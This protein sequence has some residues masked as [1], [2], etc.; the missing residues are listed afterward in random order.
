MICNLSESV[1][2]VLRLGA[3]VMLLLALASTG[4]AQV[5]AG[6]IR[7]MLSD[8]TGA[9]IP[10]AEVR[11]TNLATGVL[12]STQTTGAGVF[13]LGNLPVGDYRVEAESPGF[14]SFAQE[15][16]HVATASTTNL[17]IGLEV[18]EVTETVTV[19]GT[20]TPLL[21]T[22]TAELSTVMERKVVMDLPLALGMTAGG[23]SG[24]RQIEGFIYLTPGVTG[25]AWGK[26]FNGAPQ[27]MSQSVV[28]GI[29]HALQE[30]PGLLIRSGPPYEAVQ[31][32]KVSTAMYPAEQG[33]AFGI[34]NYTFKSG[35]NEFHGNA[36]WF[37]RNNK[38]DASGFYNAAA[39]I[40][41]QNELGATIGGPII[42]SKTFFHVAYQ[43]FS[44]RGGTSSIGLVNIPPVAFRQGDFGALKA[45]GE[46]IPI[47]DPAST[48]EDG[49]GGF[50]RDPYPNNRIPSAQISSIANQVMGFLPQP[51]NPGIV[52]NYLNRSVRPTDDN[53]YSVKVDHHLTDR[54]RI[55]FTLWRSQ[56]DLNNF[57]AWG[58]DSE[59]DNSASTFFWGGGVRVNWD[60]TVTPTVLNHFGFGFSNS[61]KDKTHN[62][63]ETVW[64]Q[65]LGVKGVDPEATGFPAFITGDY[66]QMGTSNI[67]VR[68]EDA[69]Y[70]FTDTLS[71]MRGRHQIKLG[72]EFWKQRF[73]RLRA[74]AAAGRFEFNRLSTSQPN[75]PNNSSWGDPLA[76][77]LVGEV[78]KSTR[79]VNPTA[80]VFHTRYFA[81][82][83]EDKVQLTPKLTMTLGLRYDIPVPIKGED[84]V[85]SVIDLNLANPGAGGLPGAYIFGD[86]GQPDT[87][88]REFSPRLSLA[89]RLNDKTVVRSGFGIIYSQSNA[90]SA[91]IELGGAEFLAG[92][93]DL[94][95]PRSLDQG[96]TPAF[97]LDDGFPPFE[98]T[99]PN[100]VPELN[101][102]GT[103]DYIAKDSGRA[104]YTSN[105]N[106][107]LQRELG[108]NIFTDIAYAGAKGTRMPSNLDNLNQVPASYLGLGTTLQKN[109]N[110]PEAEAAGI[111]APYPGFNGSV[112]QALRPYPQYTTL[113]IHAN[114]IGNYTYHSLQFKLQKRFSQGLSFL[115]A[116]TL[117]K[118]I[119]D[120]KGNAWANQEVKALDRERRGLE[121][122]VSPIDQ[123]HNLATTLIYELPFG[124]NSS[125]AVAKLVKG[126]QVSTVTL[127]RSG[128][129]LAIS[130]GSSMPIFGGGNRPNRVSGAERRTSIGKG[131]FDPNQHL[132]LNGGAWAPSAQFT[133][134]DGSRVEPDIRGFSNWEEN[135]SLSKRT[136]VPSI[137]EDF[138]VEFRAEFFNLFNRVVFR[139]PRTNSNSKANFGRV[140]GQ[141]NA[142]RGIQFG[143]KINF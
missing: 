99:L 143:L 45:G 105:W 15:P 57:S 30:T 103:A 33:R 121:K 56:V 7:G 53:V 71:W 18:G 73:L 94:S 130:G 14:R 66:Q 125:G 140:T 91:A 29:P 109:I 113:I 20:G 114:P 96:I 51:D 77:M 70:I 112:A 35:T 25:D 75:S 55:A 128:G 120:T 93:T 102:G 118:N 89:Y 139:D 12:N 27:Q 31:E 6:A 72:G 39:P 64:S 108:F 38:L 122:S 84:G 42:K 76:S 50:V 11:A 44:L 92:F 141:A 119:S 4:Y 101:V 124:R 60:S 36:F 34:S 3:V 80:N 110:S 129:P 95:L 68:T 142:P 106:F 10:A 86:A 87:D 13:V 137:S 78:F 133:F 26:K 46:L 111:T 54:H 1:K 82:F 16:V 2:T 59:V 28:D 22:D 100:L 40:R 115:T 63:T 138:N 123:T 24:R 85:F 32:F 107:T 116:Y 83:V 8:P 61:D 98:G 47:F 79:R 41:R 74:A 19:E 43:K 97:A 52:N 117:S 49:A 67:L 134:G 37:L 131:S 81:M 126:W 135:L 58:P 69:S 136:H 5:T 90:N 48:R 21:Q 17:N 65:Q 104:A 127:Y 62:E 132:Y 9:V 88:Y 23:G